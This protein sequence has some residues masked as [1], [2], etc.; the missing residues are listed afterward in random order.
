MLLFLSNDDI[1]FDKSINNILWTCY[2]NKD[3]MKYFGPI[4]NNR[5]P[6]NAL[7]INVSLWIITI[8][9]GK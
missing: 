3:E 9:K 1:L 5:G 2:K 7:G 4:S 6:K 8:K